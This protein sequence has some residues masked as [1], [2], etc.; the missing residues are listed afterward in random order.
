MEQSEPRIL[1][2]EPPFYR[3][4]KNTYSLERYPLSL[5][6]LAE[7]I[8]NKTNWNVMVYNSDFHPKSET[9]K[10]SYL[11]STGFEHYLNN[12][13]DVSGKVWKEIKS[14]V[15]EYKP[16]VVGISCKSQNFTSACVTAKIIKELNKQI[17]I[18]V[19]GPHPSMVGAEVLNCSYIDVCVRGEGE[20]T[21]VEL[22]NAIGAQRGYDTIQ[23]ILYKNDGHVVENALRSYIGD[24]DSLPFP[25]EHAP[26][27]LKDYNQYPLKSFGSVF[28]VRGCPYNCF[29]CGSR[30]VWSRE[31][32]F[33]SPEHVVREIQGLQKMG[34]KSIYFE[35]DIFGVNKKY[36]ND[37]CKAFITH[38]PELKW[39]CELHV[40]LVDE[41]TI[42]LMKRAGC[43]LIVVGIESG[44]NDILKKMRKNFTIDEALSACKIIKK[45]GIDLGAFFMI[46]F[47]QETEATLDDTVRAMRK[48]KCDLLYYSVFTP[49]P[50]T[51]AFQFCKEKGLIG[52]DYDV[53]LYNHQSSANYFC[54]NIVPERFRVRASRIEKMVDRKNSLKRVR[55]VFSLKTLWKMQ[56]LGI[57]NS[58]K[59][60]INIFFG[61]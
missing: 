34:L 19:G 9:M 17:T 6:Y 4:F 24:L 53:S 23:G 52:D 46:G 49:Y 54:M 37:L 42:S 60:G 57:G 32:R 22:L 48:T 40:K 2:I 13:K 38:C 43:Y 58:I 8:R 27:V 14:I 21:V 16:A 29:F 25:Y 59:R 7:S 5:G 28:A 15:A 47:P 33:R 36:I 61:K 1:L 55:R 18:I 39:G 44:N 20:N 30:K 12:L 56:E 35:D 50:A 51:E 31:V 11:T 41:E 10:N 26:E 45:H 3:L